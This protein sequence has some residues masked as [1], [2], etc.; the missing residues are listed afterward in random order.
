M[1]LFDFEQATPMVQY[2]DGTQDQYFL[3]NELLP[4]LKD[5]A[6]FYT[7]YAISTTN[8][9]ND[10]H[11]V[12]FPYTCAQETCNGGGG[13]GGKGE[14]YNSNSD[15]AYATMAYRK[16]LEYTSNTKNKTVLK[17]RELWTHALKALPSIPKVID[18]QGGNVTVFAEATTRGIK[19]PVADVNSAYAIT[20]LAAIHP[21][22]AIDSFSTTTSKEDL[23]VAQ[24]T[25][26]MI[27]RVT[28]FA[29]G[30]GY[31]LNWPAAARVHE[32]TSDSHALLMNFSESYK[33]KVK[34]NGW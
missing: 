24:N 15:I 8:G 4:Y 2:Y 19:Q 16:L 7:N 9:S 21:S 26:D 29:P 14:E 18:V 1:S 30:N 12:E 5:V 27:N 25:V 11:V 23:K 17:E 13:N 6:L 20:H 3:T 22:G 28:S 34:L 31:C 32:Y 33:S 10:S